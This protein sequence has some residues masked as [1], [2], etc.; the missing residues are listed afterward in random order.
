MITL[1]KTKKN[2]NKPKTRRLNKISILNFT[3]YKNRIRQK[4]KIQT[5]IQKVLETNMKRSHIDH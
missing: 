1:L 2:Y 3:N 4:E 5:S